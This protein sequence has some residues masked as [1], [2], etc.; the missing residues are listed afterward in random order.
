MPTILWHGTISAEW[1]V[2]VQNRLPGRPLTTLDEPTLDAA[3]RLVELQADAG[4]AA[5][6]RDFAGYVANVLFDDWADVW[7]DA[8]SACAAAGPLCARL[9][10]WLQPVWCLRLPAVDYTHNDLNL[11][12][13]LADGATITGVVDWDEF[14]LGSRALDLV[15]L[16]IDCERTGNRAAPSAC[17]PGRPTWQ[18]KQDCAACSATGRSPGWPTSPRNGRR[19]TARSVTPNAR[20]SR[21]S[22]T[23][24]RS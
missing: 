18:A 12:N 8:P 19:T 1:H 3:L 22:W 4:I 11:S 20:P 2:F 14:A 7:A 23:G 6:D 9:R 15:A 16:A 24:G 21:R 10:H 13:I 5:T 17:W